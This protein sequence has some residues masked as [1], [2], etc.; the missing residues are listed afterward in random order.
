VGSE[1][2]LSVTGSVLSDVSIGVGGTS[3]GGSCKRNRQFVKE[4]QTNTTVKQ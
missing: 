3:S 4:S 1:V 2:D